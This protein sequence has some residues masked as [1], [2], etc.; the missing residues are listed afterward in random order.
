MFK[1]FKKLKL[2]RIMPILMMAVVLFFATSISVSALELLKEYDEE[3]EGLAYGD[4]YNKVY[5]ASAEMKEYEDRNIAIELPNAVGNGIANI[6]SSIVVGIAE[7]LRVVMKN[8]QLDLTLDTIVYGRVAS[9]EQMVVDVSHF[10]L[11]KNNPYGVL[12]ASLYV[13][14]KR[15]SYAIIPVVVMALLLVNLFRNN[16]KGREQL[17]DLGSNVVI[18]FITIEL[19]PY[20][21]ELYIYIR[22]FFTYFIKRGMRELLILVLSDATPPDTSAS[23]YGMLMAV[24]MNTYSIVV[25]FLLVAVVF[26]GFF[27]LWDYVK[28]A[29][30]VAV[31]FGLFPIIVLIMFF[32]PKI[33]SDWFDILIPN[34]TIPFL[35]SI[36][37]MA[38]SLI[39]AVAGKALNI[40][41][42]FDWDEIGNGVAGDA[43]N[44]GSGISLGLCIILLCSIFTV[45]G[46][47]N[48]ILQKLFHFD[49]GVRGGGGAAML[50]MMA[51]RSML[52]KS[53]TS[54]GGGGKTGSGASTSAE[55]KAMAEEA[56][57]SGKVMEDADKLIEEDP[58]GAGSGSGTGS[59]MDAADT[60][61]ANQDVSAMDTNEMQGES[62]DEVAREG[63]VL[64]EV[65]QNESLD[66]TGVAEIA[67]SEP[68]IKRPEHSFDEGDAPV[69]SSAGTISAEEGS[70]DGGAVASRVDSEVPDTLS[71]T[72][73]NLN[74]THAGMRGSKEFAEFSERDQKR[75]ENLARMD[76]TETQIASNNKIIED[77]GYDKGTIRQQY[78]QE[79][80][81]HAELLAKE[82]ELKNSRD[83]IT[84]KSSGEYQKADAVYNEA[85]ANRERSE[86]RL[87]DMQRSYNA[88][89]QNV[90]HSRNLEHYRQVERQY[91]QNSG[92]GGM[93]TRTYNNASDFFNQKRVEQI[94]KRQADYRNFDS[95]NFDGILSPQERENFYRERAAQ[96]RRDE[97]AQKARNV[98]KAVGGTFGAA[99]GTFGGASAMAAGAAIG[100]GIIGG[101]TGKAA[102]GISG[103]RQGEVTDSQ[104][105][106]NIERSVRIEAEQV[107]KETFA[108]AER[109]RVRNEQSAGVGDSSSSYE[110]STL[111]NMHAKNKDG[112]EYTHARRDN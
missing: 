54:S 75:F 100:G 9:S 67:E 68:T 20:I 87:G 72:D 78:K 14:L 41:A 13:M 62:T 84:D 19:M 73:S 66:D 60:E 21:V 45:K 31:T 32:K 2:N 71:R 39:L 92:L 11:E 27:Y 30:L 107:Q 34:L 44:M 101:A 48:S 94:Q 23:I 29:L 50:V 112:I 38:P 42:T 103:I 91:A 76:D 49:G 52:S 37:L 8:G 83:M 4:E 10:G 70:G 79:S 1:K 86:G 46:I 89:Q 69:N 58:A 96:Q 55:S 93:S 109:K 53:S 3:T 80:V 88:A 74:D 24:Y 105:N 56:S 18:Y 36:L 111:N 16:R 90:E 97:I 26:A 35:D 102:H 25:A 64:E 85:K 77:A 12:G 61:L 51:A 43:V 57:E 59:S 95:G 108:Q 15:A 17:K 65:P 99:A 47:R 22:A 33:V 110:Q 6:L 40:G 106:K 104:Q 7:L 98:G 5:G 82:N 63:E 28:I 81:N